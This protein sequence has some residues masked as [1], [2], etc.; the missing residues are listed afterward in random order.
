MMRCKTK[1]INIIKKKIV[2]FLLKNN[3]KLEW[4]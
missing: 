3:V 1:H 2:M 4:Y